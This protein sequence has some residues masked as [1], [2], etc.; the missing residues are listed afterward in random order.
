M[1]QR[2]QPRLRFYETMMADLATQSISLP[3]RN[4]EEFLG[5]AA[6]DGSR[7]QELAENRH[8]ETLRWMLRLPFYM[9]QK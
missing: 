4:Q 1:R 3:V 8:E 2:G 6:G 7:P 5:A 9:A